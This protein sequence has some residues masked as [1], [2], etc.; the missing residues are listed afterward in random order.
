MVGTLKPSQQTAPVAVET[1]LGKDAFIL[2]SLSWR[3]SLGY[4]FEGELELRAPSN[5]HSN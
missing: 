2:T 3:E 4:P 1:A 5:A